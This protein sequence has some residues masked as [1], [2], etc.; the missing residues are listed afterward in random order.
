MSSY[1]V[2]KHLNSDINVGTK[3]NHD[4]ASALRVGKSGYSKEASYEEILNLALT[5]K[6]NVI[7]KHG[8]GKWYLKKVNDEVISSNIA[9]S[10]LY[11]LAGRELY[12]IKYN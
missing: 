9:S 12:Y 3:F 10:S 1:S 2:T 5:E 11:E 4:V 6:C 7:V 8:K